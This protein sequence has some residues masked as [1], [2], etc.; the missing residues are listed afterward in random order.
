MLCLQDGTD[1]NFTTR[2]QTRGIGVIGRNQTGAES[3]GLHLH[4]TLA[5][6]ADGLPLGVLQAQFEAPQPRGEEVPPQE[7]KK[8]FRWIAGLR[9]TA[10][11]AATLPNTRVVS[12][13]DREAD[14]FE[15]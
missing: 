3:L 8:S 1:L 10:A 5:V 4:S 7:E 9:D 15:L 6:N 2:P 14:A 13:A 11:L 12:V